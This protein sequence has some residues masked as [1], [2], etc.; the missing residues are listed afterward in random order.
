MKDWI[1][2]QVIQAVRKRQGSFLRKIE[3]LV[4]AE[5][6]GVPGGT[7]AWAFVDEETKK[8]FQEK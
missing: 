8:R 2:R 5:N 6:M 7:L 1:A 3:S 4:E